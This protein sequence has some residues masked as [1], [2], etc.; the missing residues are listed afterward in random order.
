LSGTAPIVGYVGKVPS[1]G[2]F[3][4]LGLPATFS[5]PWDAWVRATMADAQERLGTSWASTFLRNPVWRFVLT[6]G[7]CG[8]APWLG[9]VASSLDR[10]GRLYPMT[11]ALTPPE[12]VPLITL[13]DQ[14]EHGFERMTDLALQMLRDDVAFDR[15]AAGLARFGESVALPPAR[16]LPPPSTDGVPLAPGESVRVVPED[17]RNLRRAVSEAM[18]RAGNAAA[19]MWPVGWGLPPFAIVSAGLADTRRSPSIWESA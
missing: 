14:W 13:L 18:A 15:A 19:I 16:L 9:V 11:I 6:P 1:R 5:E 8:P 12:Y 7:V 2:D 17:G 4:G 10:I 3:V